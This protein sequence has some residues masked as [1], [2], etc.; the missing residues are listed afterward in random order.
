MDREVSEP[1]ENRVLPFT[2][3]QFNGSAY[4]GLVVPGIPLLAF[5]VVNWTVESHARSAKFQWLTFA[6]S[7]LTSDSEGQLAFVGYWGVGT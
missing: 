1:G 3:S 7:N 6:T 2:T 4:I 5:V